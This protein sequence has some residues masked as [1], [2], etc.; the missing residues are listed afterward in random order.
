MGKKRVYSSHHVR[1]R[2]R[3]ETK[4]PL[5]KE[6]NLPKLFHSSW[7]FVFGNLFGREVELFV[8]E[9][10]KI[11]DEQETITPKQLEDLRNEIKALELYEFERR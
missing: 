2:S 8:Q 4:L 5:D 10:N 9:V 11:M 1:P 3:K 6:I 7:H